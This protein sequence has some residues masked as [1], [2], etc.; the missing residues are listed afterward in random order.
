MKSFYADDW[1]LLVSREDKSEVVNM[2]GAE[3]H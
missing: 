3:L 2:L 1:A